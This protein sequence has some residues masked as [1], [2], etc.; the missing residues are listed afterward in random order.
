MKETIT[1]SRRDGFWLARFSITGTEVPTPYK[2]HFDGR[3]LQE[4]IQ[5]LNP[6]C[7]VRIANA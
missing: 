6:D 2:A 1:P 5:R 7:T 3:V 4:R